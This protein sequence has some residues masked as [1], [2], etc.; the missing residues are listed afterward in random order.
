MVFG[1]EVVVSGVGGMGCRCI[2]MIVRVEDDCLV[3]GDVI[4]MY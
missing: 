1:L 3:G 2:G 4:K